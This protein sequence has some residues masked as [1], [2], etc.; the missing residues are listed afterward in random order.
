MAVVP[1]RNKTDEDFSVNINNVNKNIP[2]SI[3]H[4][5]SR[6]DNTNY[7]KKVNIDQVLNETSI[8]LIQK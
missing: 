8:Y 6:L 4:K 1:E 2:T 7:Q 5:D 3:L